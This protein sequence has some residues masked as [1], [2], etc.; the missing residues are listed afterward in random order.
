MKV[1]LLFK[2]NP[3]IVNTQQNITPNGLFYIAALL[4][5]KNVDTE[6]L[7]LTG[8]GWE[9]CRWII[10][11]KKPDIV[12]ISC[13]SFNRHTCIELA[14]IVKEINKDIKVVFGGP[15]SSVMYKQLIENYEEIDVVVIN[16]GEMTFLDITKG[17][18][19]DI[20]GVVYKVDNKIINNGFRKPLENLDELPI[21]ANYFKYKRIVTSRGCPGNCIFCDTPYLWGRK[22]RFR[23]PKNI[24]DELK[25]LN[26]KYGISNFIIS[27]DTF[28]FDKKRTIDVCKE[29]IRRG[30]K[31]TW[32]CR[33][34]VN[35]ICE[36]RMGWMKKAGCT[37]L[38]FGIESGSQKILNNLKKGITVTQ[39]KRA[40]ELT[41]KF[42]FTLNYFIIV[43]SPG[44]TIETI[45]E[46]IKLIEETKPTAISTYIMQLTPGTQIYEF[47]KEHHFISDVD[48]M[49]SKEE[50]I[51]YTYEKS[52]T[53]LRDFAGSIQDFYGFS[54][55]KFQYSEEGLKSIIKEGNGIKDLIN[56]A[57][58]YFSNKKY[59]EA[60]KVVEETL[61]LNPSSSEALMLKAVLLAMRKDDYCIDLFNKTIIADPEN[62][63]AYQN[64]GLF[65]FNKARYE[66][67][68]EIFKKAIGAEPA[69][70]EFYNDLGSIYGI[71]KNYEK[72]IETFK[73]ALQ[74]EPR[75]KGALKNL[76]VTY[77]IIKELNSKDV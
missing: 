70:P 62:L 31:I 23:S 41:R 30:L 65:L 38:S 47:A 19:K 7:N 73:K 32:D 16:E 68:A 6:V 66:E 27:D 11:E 44:E 13:Y 51:F 22:V 21:P 49:T 36:E 72:A 59:D 52:L 18:L 34:R 60:E 14:K 35:F 10:E 5:S 15:H 2:P 50:T 28:T 17:G 8:A 40:A 46:T 55:D 24:V 26:K 48:W 74:I 77:S 69:H 63:L 45:K 61:T 53:E 29:I 39:I 37:V 4:L 75:N 64:F 67:A 57:N 54:K 71:Q 33:T 56:L 20:P 12:G 3:V 9:E 1:L 42:G 58:I 76:A 43:G 25:I